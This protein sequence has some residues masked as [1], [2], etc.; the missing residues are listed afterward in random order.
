[1]KESLPVQLF[2]E[3]EFLFSE[4]AKFLSEV[5]SGFSSKKSAHFCVPV[6]SFEFY[7][8]VLTKELREGDKS[9]D[10]S[11]EVINDFN[12]SRKLFQN[13]W[14]RFVLSICTVKLELNVQISHFCRGSKKLSFWSKNA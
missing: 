3:W 4:R 5:T 7:S 2:Y 1:M 9:P 12:G 10:P 8:H 6:N 14:Q 11:P 13:C